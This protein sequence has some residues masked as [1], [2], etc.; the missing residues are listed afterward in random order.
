M[1]RVGV[2]RVD[3]H[4]EQLEAAALQ[5]RVFDGLLHDDPRRLRTVVADEPATG[6]D[7]VVVE[8]GPD[9]VGVATVDRPPRFDQHRVVAGERGGG[10]MFRQHLEEL[11][12]QCTVDRH[13]RQ[14]TLASV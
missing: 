10:T 8:H 3:G 7:L 12:A 11:G 6:P 4:L 1:L 13:R 5:A 9:A 2:A 14:G